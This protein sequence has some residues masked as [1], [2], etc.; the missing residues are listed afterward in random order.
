ML[1][2]TVFP[3]SPDFPPVHLAIN[4]RPSGHLTHFETTLSANRTQKAHSSEAICPSF[5]LWN[6]EAVIAE[7]FVV[8]ALH[9]SSPKE[10][11]AAPWVATAEDFPNR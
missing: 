2:V 4:Q 8:Q 11:G 10:E 1:S 5:T 3:W 7:R 6:F 9:Q